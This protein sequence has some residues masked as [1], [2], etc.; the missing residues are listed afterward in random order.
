MTHVENVAIVRAQYDAFNEQNLDAAME[1]LADDLQWLEIPTGQTRGKNDY[2]QYSQTW[3]TA[4]PDNKVEITNIIST[5]DWVVAENVV[6]GTHTGPLEGPGGVIQPTRKTISLPGCDI[7]QIRNGKIVSVHSY[8][9]MA[10]LL[11]Q[12]GMTELP[13]AA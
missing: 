9:D 5:E 2:K 7:W 3:I 8:Y 10:S 4:F 1:T 12:L 13:K 6:R 11:F